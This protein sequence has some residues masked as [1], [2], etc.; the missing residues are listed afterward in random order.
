M[1]DKNDNYKTSDLALAAALICHGHNL[2]TLDKHNAKR[3]LF[4]FQQSDNLNES[5]NGYWENLL[6]I[7]PRQYFD[8][9]RNLKAR[10]YSES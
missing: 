6:T 1:H 3:V 2:E 8:A 4:I 9:I 5:L 7:N 10:L